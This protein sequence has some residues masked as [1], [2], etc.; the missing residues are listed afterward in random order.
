MDSESAREVALQYLG[1]DAGTAGPFAKGA[2]REF[3]V[4]SP[5]DEREASELIDR[6][7]VAFLVFEARASAVTRIVLI[8]R[9]RVVGDFPVAKPEP[10]KTPEPTRGSVTPRAD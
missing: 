5:K 2:K 1:S 10:N 3:S 7:A 8:H 4:L 9:G 6:G